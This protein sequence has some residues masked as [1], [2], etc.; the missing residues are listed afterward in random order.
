[1]SSPKSLES[2]GDIEN[3]GEVAPLEKGVQPPVNH[4]DED[5]KDT[6]YGDTS[7][8]IWKLYSVESEKYDMA[9]VNGWK[10]S[11][12]S[13]LIFTGLFSTIVAAFLIETY[14]TLQPD[15]GTQTVAILTQLATRPDSAAIPI[16]SLD[17]ALE[18]TTP[19]FA[20]RVNTFMFL[21]LFLSMT[22]ALASTLIQQWAR[23]YLQYSQPNAA[24]HKRGR[25]RA[26]LFEGLSQF[27]MRR[28]VHGV[29]VL[30][31]VSVF[32]FFFALS[33]FLHSVDG[34]VGM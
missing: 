31:H 21:S 1:M 27:Q 5:N 15:T 25:V 28:L 22:S 12:D 23:D 26:Y 11:A 24:P 32:L 14:K 3:R 17:K 8:Q 19:A 16:S 20:V 29:P 9:L 2:P 34:L 7:T 30:L 10:A 6:G 33:D 4:V 18:F 13:M